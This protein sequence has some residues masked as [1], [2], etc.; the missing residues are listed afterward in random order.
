MKAVLTLLAAS[1]A[2]TTL[3]VSASA[4]DEYVPF[5]TD[6]PSGAPAAPPADVAA[7]VSERFD[8]VDAAFGAAGGFVL[9]SLVA[10]SLPA[11]R[12]D[13]SVSTA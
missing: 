6:F 12:R 7:P 11:R 8:W 9:G 5:V 2:A 13:T 10:A 4:A 3:A 1:L